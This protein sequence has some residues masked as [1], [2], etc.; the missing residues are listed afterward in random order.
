M[1]GESSGRPAPA[2]TKFSKFYWE[3]VRAAVIFKK[4]LAEKEAVLKKK[5]AARAE[6]AQLARRLASAFSTT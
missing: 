5:E 6:R 3:G 2:R 4:K 1:A